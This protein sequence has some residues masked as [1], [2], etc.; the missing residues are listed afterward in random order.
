VTIIDICIMLQTNAD[1]LVKSSAEPIQ[2][3][4]YTYYL[5]ICQHQWVIFL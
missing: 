2:E 1:L 4:L 3:L 5:N